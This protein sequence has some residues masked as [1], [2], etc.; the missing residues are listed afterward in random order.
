M[1][2]ITD[3]QIFYQHDDSCAKTYIV[4]VRA[5]I[6]SARLVEVFKTRVNKQND[7]SGKF[8]HT[9]FMIFIGERHDTAKKVTATSNKEVKQITKRWKKSYSLVD[10]DYPDTK[11]GIEAM[12]L[13]LMK[14]TTECVKAATKT[15]LK[16]PKSSNQVAMDYLNSVLDDQVNTKKVAS[17]MYALVDL[18][19]G[20]AETT[21][22]AKP[23]L[24]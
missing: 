13:E 11:D 7:S 20:P 16:T 21:I 22:K 2:E 14:T 8:E 23:D 12:S 1:V 10:A 9:P 4:R 15:R 18:V 3:P 19:T 6:D 17:S 24:K 5:N